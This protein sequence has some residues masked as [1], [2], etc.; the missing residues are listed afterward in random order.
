MG[1]LSALAAHDLGYLSSS[2]LA[3]RLDRTLTTLE[4]LE[5]H[6]GHF[7][8]WYDTATR[9]PLHPRYVSTVDSG[10]LAA[11]L[12]ALAQGLVALIDSPQTYAQRLEGVADTAA[13]SAAVSASSRGTAAI[14]RTV[15]HAGL[16]HH[17]STP[18]HHR[19]V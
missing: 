17:R 16:L 15:R 19:T 11:A 8:N 18:G 6:E 1:L 3:R 2:E 4:G 13:V 10:N 7:L 5:R 9:A 14:R 12:I